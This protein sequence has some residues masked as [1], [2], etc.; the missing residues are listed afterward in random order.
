MIAFLL[1]ARL[2]NAAACA[3]AGRHCLCYWHCGMLRSLQELPYGFWTCFLPNKQ[4]LYNAF[5]TQNF[6]AH[7]DVRGLAALH[8]WRKDSIRIRSSSWVFVLFLNAF[9]LPGLGAEGSTS[10]RAVLQ[11]CGHCFFLLSLSQYMSCAVEPSPTAQFNRIGWEAVHS[12]LLF[13][14]GWIHLFVPLAKHW[15]FGG[16]SLPAA[17]LL[18]F[19]HM[20]P[21]LQHV[22]QIVPL[23]PRLGNGS[24]TKALSLCAPFHPAEE[25][26]T[27]PCWTGSL[28]S[29]CRLARPGSVCC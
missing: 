7:W 11:D 14:S 13:L 3:V 25:R 22:R 1:G 26:E 18:L 9:K 4:R 10:F 21:E 2:K 17:P 15:K 16:E 23:K 12:P 29:C 28:S 20:L 24:S 27:V 5:E 8:V 6:G 19:L